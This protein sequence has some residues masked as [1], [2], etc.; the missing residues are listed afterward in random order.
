MD[1]E[2]A[3]TDLKITLTTMKTMWNLCISRVPRNKGR[4]TKSACHQMGILISGKRIFNK[5]NWNTCF[6]T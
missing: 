6:N 3:L 4:D 2:Q 1:E 5:R